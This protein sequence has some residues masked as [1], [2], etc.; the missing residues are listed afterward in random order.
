MNEDRLWYRPNSET[1]KPFQQMEVKETGEGSLSHL[2]SPSSPMT[3]RGTVSMR[4]DRQGLNETKN[5][6]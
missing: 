3:D 4:V 6:F 2:K 1:S 5:F